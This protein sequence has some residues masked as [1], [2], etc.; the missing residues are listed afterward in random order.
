MVWQKSIVGS[1]YRSFWATQRSLG[2]S[3][4]QSSTIPTLP[5]YEKKESPLSHLKDYVGEKYNGTFHVAIFSGQPELNVQQQKLRQSVYSALQMERIDIHDWPALQ[6]FVDRII[7]QDRTRAVEACREMWLDLGNKHQQFFARGSYS[8]DALFIQMSPESESSILQIYRVISKMLPQMMPPKVTELLFERYYLFGLH[9]HSEQ[10][11][12]IIGGVDSLTSMNR[13]KLLS[14]R[15]RSRRFR[16]YWE[17]FQEYRLVRDWC[18][19]RGIRDIF[20]SENWFRVCYNLTRVS[21]Y[22]TESTPSI[23][24]EITAELL[25]DFDNLAQS[26]EHIRLKLINLFLNH[27]GKMSSKSV[28]SRWLLHHQQIIVSLHEGLVERYG[29]DLNGDVITL[30]SLLEA[31]GRAEMPDS[32]IEIWNKMVNLNVQIDSATI[33]TIFDICGLRGRLSDASKI[34]EWLQHGERFLELMEKNAWDSWLECLCR[35]GALREAMDYTF[36]FME[37]Q[38][39]ERALKFKDT[40]ATRISTSPKQIYYRKLESEMMR[41]DV[42]EHPGKQE[43]PLESAIQSQQLRKYSSKGLSTIAPDATTFNL[44][45]SFSHSKRYSSSYGSANPEL[46]AE[47][48]QRLHQD[49]LQLVP[50]IRDDYIIPL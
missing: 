40:G 27:Y 6:N 26:D 25:T 13:L 24:I 5:R 47:I 4:R 3:I 19:E 30:T 42:H 49:Y 39:R 29:D 46:H 12:D 35:C 43:F 16:D 14:I 7:V 8:E 36:Q 32:A 41:K 2:L 44:L 18:L 34:F 33:S 1:M 38:L 37:P 22:N 21:I 23:P 17:A 9:S 31:Y 48:L 15:L 11:L 10:L 45:L 20:P 50:F 28:D